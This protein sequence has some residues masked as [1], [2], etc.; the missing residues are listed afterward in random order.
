M[1]PEELKELDEFIFDYYNEEGR[2]LGTEPYG[3]SILFTKDS[4]LKVEEKPLEEGDI[5]FYGILTD[6]YQR[7]IITEAVEAHIGG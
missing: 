3:G 5:S 4:N 6:A 2:K 1:T 7:E